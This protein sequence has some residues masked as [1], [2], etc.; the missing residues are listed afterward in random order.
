MAVERTNSV[1]IT[2]AFE[3]ATSRTIR[4]NGVEDA[5]LNAVKSRV[6]QLNEDFPPE[7]STTFVSAIGAESTMI[8][9]VII[10]STQKEVIY[11]G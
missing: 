8:S 11:S 6:K 4:F 1:A 10:T 7:V 5:A 3:D 9:K 2:L